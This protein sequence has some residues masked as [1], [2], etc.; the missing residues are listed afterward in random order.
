MNNETKQLI[1]LRD[2]RNSFFLKVQTEPTARGRAKDMKN[3]TLVLL[4]SVGQCRRVVNI[5]KNLFLKA[6]KGKLIKE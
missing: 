1:R 6:L 5:F 3:A 4:P 2:L